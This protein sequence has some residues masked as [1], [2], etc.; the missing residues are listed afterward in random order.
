MTADPSPGAGSGA[1][2]LRVGHGVAP[3]PVAPGAPLGGY[4]AR[5]GPATGVLDELEVAAVSLA[6]G[7]RRLIWVVSDLPCVNSDL[8]GAVR[9]A[10]AA[11]VPDADPEDVWL[12][13]THTHAA[14]ETGC[15]PG[16]APTPVPW[17]AA[18]PRAAATAAAIAVAAEQPSTVE[19]R[20]EPLDG[21]GGQR[22]G[23]DPVRTVPL[24]ILSFPAPD[25]TLHGTVV[26]LPVHPTVLSADNLLV[27]ADL[28][29]AVRRALADAVAP[30]WVM[31]A[32]GAAGDVSTR[33]HRR[34]QTPA[35]CDRL[36]RLVADAVVRGL[37]APARA[38]LGGDTEL[39]VSRERVPV[40]PKPP[41]DPA[42]VPRLEDKL[43]QVE[44]TGDPVAT[45]TAYTAL[46]AARLAAAEPVPPADLSC[47]VSVA[48][49]GRL[50][51]VGLGAE[52]FLDLAAR[53]DN[54]A[55]AA[56]GA[57]VR[58]ILIGYTNGYLGYLPVRGAYQRTDYEVLRSPVAAGGA[59]NVLDRAAALVLSTI[60][61]S[62]EPR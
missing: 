52:P 22:S 31:V 10:V 34:E 53:L 47:V 11:A 30:A 37:R 4:A 54:A 43:R 15:Q 50:A 6:A 41:P 42:M 18:V 24:D 38:A 26:I 7:D 28:T 19:V 8:A 55:T 35:E 56:G 16:G 44:A 33:P 32:T 29:G 48:R 36:G 25:G 1:A 3:L 9:D 62:E 39:R 21:V 23:A 2:K 59:E 45:R 57:A 61:T 40:A 14:P 60:D 12:S 5:P 51:L 49:L 13:A 17:L 46:Q 27:S 20:R 58:T